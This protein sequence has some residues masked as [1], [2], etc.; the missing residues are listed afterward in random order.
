MTSNSRLGDVFLRKS[1]KNRIILTCGEILASK[2]LQLGKS[3]SRARCAKTKRGCKCP[4]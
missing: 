3:R 1:R 2:L 4:N